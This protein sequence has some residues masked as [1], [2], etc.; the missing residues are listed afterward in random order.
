MH[1]VFSSS[2]CKKIVCEWLSLD[3]LIKQRRE[4]LIK[5]AKRRGRMTDPILHFKKERK[6]YEILCLFFAIYF[7]NNAI[8]SPYVTN[9]EWDIWAEKKILD[10]EMPKLFSPKQA[11]FIWPNCWST[12]NVCFLPWK[13]KILF[14]LRMKKEKETFSFPPTQQKKE[15]FF[16]SSCLSFEPQVKLAKAVSLNHNFS[17]LSLSLF[18]L[19]SFLS[20]LFSW[21]RPFI[22]EQKLDSLFFPEKREC[23]GFEILPTNK[24][25]FTF[26]LFCTNEIS[27]SHQGKIKVKLDFS[28]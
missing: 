28:L 20:F 11:K 5:G 16:F 19:F 24:R 15:L 4:R 14:R 3:S 22:M 18:S 23:Q 21:L 12:V 25:A 27:N 6:G 1:K 9:S 7:R 10:K 26:S 8:H 17:L 2:L 13:G